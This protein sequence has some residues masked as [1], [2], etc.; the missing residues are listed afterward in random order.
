MQLSL[1]MLADRVDLTLGHGALEWR[2][3]RFA[4]NGMGMPAAIVNDLFR[5][6]KKTGREGTLKGAEQRVGFA[7][8]Q[9]VL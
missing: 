1:A 3:W 9:G 2:G 7:G 4:D 8:L 6:D 5:I